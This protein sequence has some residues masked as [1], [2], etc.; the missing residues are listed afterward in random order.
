MKKGCSSIIGSG[1][2]AIEKWGHILF[3]AQ[4]KSEF[5]IFD[6]RLRIEI[7]NKNRQGREKNGIETVFGISA[8]REK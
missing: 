7:S 4:D 8:R 1:C 3:F 5:Q 2:I 6:F